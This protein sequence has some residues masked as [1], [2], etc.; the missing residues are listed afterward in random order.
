MPLLFSSLDYDEFEAYTVKITRDSEMEIEAELGQGIMDKVS[1]GIK[2]RRF[3]S[4]LRFLYDRSMPEE[5]K[6]YIEE[7]CPNHHTVIVG[8]FE[9]ITRFGSCSVD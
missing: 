9:Q 3:G 7:R 2:S 6:K 4:P 1:K 5:M 8:V